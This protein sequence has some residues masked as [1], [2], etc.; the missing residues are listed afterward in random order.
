[1]ARDAIARQYD[2]DKNS[3]KL[4]MEDAAGDYRPGTISFCAKNGKS[5]NLDQIR[6]SIQ[7][8]RLSGNTQMQVTYLEVTAVGEVTMAQTQMLF[9]VKGSGQAR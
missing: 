4:E 2:V 1:M 5:I 6:E 8:T 7:A 9:K 3:V